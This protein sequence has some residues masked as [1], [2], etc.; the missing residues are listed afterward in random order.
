MMAI[1]EARKLFSFAEGATYLDHGAFGVAPSEVLRVA[2]QM[3]EWVEASPRPFFDNEC[4]PRWREAAALVAARFAARAEDLA[5][6]DNV[7][8]GVNAVLRSLSFK[9]GDEILLNSMSYGAV[10]NAV[11]R[12]ARGQGARVV[13]ARLPFP[14]PSVDGCVEAIRAALGPNVRLAVLDHIASATALV[15][16]VAEMT[17]ACRERGVAALVD[18]AHAPGHIPLDIEAIGADWYVANL[19][20]WHFVPR[21]C[22]FLW[23]RRDRQ[24]SLVPTVLSWDI[25]KPF[26]HSFE[27]TGTRDPSSWLSLP[28]AFAF[29]DR[30]GQENVRRH[31]HDLVVAGAT[32]LADAWDVPLETPASMTGAMALVPLPLRSAFAP[33]LEAR[34]A[35]QKALWQAH[36]IACA[37]ML[38]EGRLYLRV[39]AQIYNTIDDYEKLAQAVGKL[40]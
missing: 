14:A 36:G 31:N 20:K 19:H 3:R 35:V 39:A 24:E 2:A 32:L 33:T 12:I 16:P 29:M 40:E 27:W 13:E 8:D 38:F 22:G 25:D 18:G 7:T 23:A 17:R 30:F 21:A 26:P 1:G 9:P 15:L 10:A 5:L 37:C 6:V 34:E 28:A 4:R 11:R